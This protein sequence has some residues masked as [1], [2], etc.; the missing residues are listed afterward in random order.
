LDAAVAASPYWRRDARDG[1]A[2]RFGV[3][4]AS[5]LLRGLALDFVGYAYDAKRHSGIRLGA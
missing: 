3:L 5:S 1:G 4:R 2:C